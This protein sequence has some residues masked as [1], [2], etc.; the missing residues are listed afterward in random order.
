MGA[1]SSSV[2]GL[3]V[4]SGF[5]PALRWA[6][7]ASPLRLTVSSRLAYDHGSLSRYTDVIFQ[8]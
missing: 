1:P 5:C 7:A 3:R 6:Q 2:V 8:G 4:A